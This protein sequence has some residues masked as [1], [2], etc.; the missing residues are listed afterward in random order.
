MPDFPLVPARAASLD[1]RARSAASTFLALFTVLASTATPASASHDPNRTVTVFVHGF[2]RDGADRLGVYGMDIHDALED[3]LGAMAGLAVADTTGGPIPPDAITATTYYGDTAPPYFTADDNAAI[4]QL[5]A[6]WG[7]G[8]PRYAYIVA[9]FAQ[10]AM[11]RSGADQVNFVSASLGSLVV[12]WAIE[13]N[14][15]GLAGS[16]RIAR[17]LTIEGLIAGN[18]AASRSDLRHYLDIVMPEPI[19]VDHMA[20]DWVNANLHSPRTEGDSPFY[21]DI[22]IGQEASTD[23]S[24]N[25]GVLSDAML[26]YNEYMPNDGTQAVPD[27]LFQTMTSQSRF[28]GRTPTLALMHIDHLG[29]KHFAPAYAEAVTFI[30]GQRRVTVTMTSARVTNL[31]E[32]F[33]LTPAEVVFESWA[34][35]PAVEARWGIT[36]PLSAHSKEDAVAPLHRFQNAGDTQTLDDVVFDDFVLPEETTLHITLHAAEVDYDPDYGVFETVTTPYYDDMGGGALDVS[37]LQPGTYP[38]A[39]ADWSC[40]LTVSVFDYPFTAL[41]AVPVAGSSQVARGLVIAP[42]PSSSLARIGL[43]GVAVAGDEPAHLAIADLSGRVV[44]AIEGSVGGSF[45]WDGRDDAGRA[46][47][48]G[49]YWYRLT[50]AR[51]TWTGRSVRVR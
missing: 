24:A 20:Y 38:F 11:A 28:Q 41:T 13:K 42:N 25:N 31:H 40:V 47:P 15:A 44:R 26:A 18:W 32:P 35:S 8:V 46:L 39:L 50:T 45:V 6:T 1:R 16:G 17:W 30:A 23:D 19:D 43:A 14:M 3:S 37:T 27:A 12:R 21:G 9:R 10:Q 48:A 49:V 51:G 2:E 5:T 4:A 34:N 7:G 29:V 33:F 22:L 36:G